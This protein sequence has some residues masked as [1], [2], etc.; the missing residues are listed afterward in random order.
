MK[1]RPL[2]Q[3]AALPKEHQAQLADWV[4]TLRLAKT[5]ELAKEHL[6]ED[7]GK[8]HCTANA[9]AVLPLKLIRVH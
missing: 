2:T 7:I 5:I 9:S 8:P 4:T 1:L 3:I 6:G